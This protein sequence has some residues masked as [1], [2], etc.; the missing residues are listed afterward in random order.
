MDTN[1]L[2][3][4]VIAIL[5]PP[6]AVFLKKGMGKDLLINIILCLLFFVPGLIHAI[7]VVIQD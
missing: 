2:L 5:L 7:W 3:L 1:K 4:I 6:V